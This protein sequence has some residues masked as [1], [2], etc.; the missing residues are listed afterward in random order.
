MR[1]NPFSLSATKAAAETMFITDK[2]GTT[3]FFPWGHQKTGYVLTDPE[4][5][6]KFT[7]FYSWAFL[8]FLY[9]LGLCLA[10]ADLLHNVKI[11]FI[12]PPACFAVWLLVYR[13]YTNRIIHALPIAKLKYSDIVLDLWI[14]DDESP[15]E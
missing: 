8:L 3:Y 1:I 9:A 5:R 4:I 2:N 15:L 6:E 14:P 13:N 11:L 12:G 7:H 10:C